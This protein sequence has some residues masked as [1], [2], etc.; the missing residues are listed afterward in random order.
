MYRSATLIIDMKAAMRAIPEAGEGVEE[1][2]EVEEVE[3]AE[4]RHQRP[5]AGEADNRQTATIRLN[6]APPV[7]ARSEMPQIQ[8]RAKVKASNW[9]LRPRTSPTTA[10]CAS[11]APPKSSTRLLRLVT[12]GLAI[13]VR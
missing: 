10:R 7:I 4:H 9:L 2:E 1:E 5:T 12:T 8:Q 11:S 13:S 3:D 6:L